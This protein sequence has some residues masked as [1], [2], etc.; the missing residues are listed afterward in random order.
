M[1]G[2]P[3]PARVPRRSARGKRRVRTAMGTG[4]RQPE[5]DGHAPVRL[6]EMVAES[7]APALADSFPPQTCLKAAVVAALLVWLNFWQLRVLTAR[8]MDDP[9]WSHGFLIP[10]FSL[11]LLYARRAELL[12]AKRR[13][14]LWGLPIMLL[15]LLQVP[16]GTFYFRNNWFSHLGLIVLLFGTVLYL[17]GPAVIRVVWLP[18]V[19]LVFAMP[20]PDYVYSRI[21]LPLQNLAAAASRVVLGLFMTINSKESSLVLISRT[22]VE[23]PLQVAEACAG[24]RLLVAFLALGVA[25]AYLDE[26]PLWQRA[27]L[28]VM[29]GPIAIVCNVLRVTITCAMNWLDR[30]QLGEGFMHD[31]TGMLMLAPALLML[32]ALS[33]LLRRLF[34][35]E[36]ADD[37]RPGDGRTCEA[38]P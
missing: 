2:G 23:R 21:A 4:P 11:Y 26:R 33:W 12:G 22:G 15:G 34:V 20:L 6:A 35:E 30:P 3:L 36:D 19:F 7:A 5:A 1:D 29:G 37:D 38:R 31:F 24:I 28:V 27:V 9:N 17:A 16:A 14:C 8:W 13:S 25:M 32:G 10:L 18:I